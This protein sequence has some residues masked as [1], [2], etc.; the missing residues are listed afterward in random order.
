MKKILMV[1][2]NGLGNGGIQH[3]MMD[4]VRGLHQDFHFD[5]LLFVKEEGFFDK[6][7][8]Q[9][10]SIFRLPHYSG[11]WKWRTRIDRYIRFYRLYKGV[12]KILRE[13]GPYDIIHCHNYWD[14]APCLLAAKHCGV[15]V[16]ISHSH[17]AFLRH[18]PI[19]EIHHAIHAYLINKYATHQ[20]GC[21]QMAADYLFGPS[22]GISIP[23]SID[24][25]R[26][27]ISK[28]SKSKITHSF[29]H[30]GSFGLQKNQ[31]FLLDVFNVIQQRWPDSTLKLISPS[32][33][34]YA[35]KLHQKI[36]DLHIRNVEFLP[37]N[38]DVPA[39]LAQSEYMIFPSTFEGFGIALA[40]A[41]AMHVK[42]FAS[43]CIPHEVDIGL[44]R[45]LSLKQSAREWA[46]A[47]LAEEKHP[48]RTPN[49][50][51]VNLTHYIDQIR[52]IYEQK[53]IQ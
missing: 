53:S 46:Q 12:K 5:M 19:A 27:D 48:L 16:R 6:E 52:R 18:H 1:G 23:N 35:Q 28:Y 21:S 8:E 24:S 26:F 25:Q 30:V 17:N 37:H 38:T 22:R 4:I 51:K 11:P 3:V 43:D 10:G 14:A 41:Q 32:R 15:P 9:Y 34:E 20:I 50:E 29:I 49:I 42:C 36:K 7:F 47:V 2:N 31:L 13:N 45:F 39:L 44:C 40:E 33:P